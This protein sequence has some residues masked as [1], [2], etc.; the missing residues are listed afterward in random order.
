MA[1]EHNFL[2]GKGEKLTIPVEVPS[3]G[4]EKAPPYKFEVAKQRVAKK[5]ESANKI[6]SNIP[7]EACPND[8]V[9]GVITIHPRYISKSDFPENFLNQSG[10]RAIGTRPKKIKP[11]AW[12]IKKHPQEAS[13]EQI[14]VAGKKSTFNKWL[15]NI[16]SWDENSQG[17]STLSQ[18]EDFSPFIAEDKIRGIPDTKKK[19]FLEV[20]IHNLG[21]KQAI[22]E[23]SN[24]AKTLGGE[25]LRNRIRTIG[26]LTFVPT[27]IDQSRVTELATFSFVRVARGMPTVRPFPTTALRSSSGFNVTLPDQGP[28][29][30]NVR[31]VIFDGGLP[32]SVDLN[33]WCNYHE[34]VGIGNPLPGGVVHGL[35]VTSA[36]LF[37]SLVDG[38]ALRQPFCPVDHVRVIGDTDNYDLQ[39]IDI[40][41]R[42][43][44]YLDQHQ[45]EYQFVNLSLGPDFS[46]EDDEVNQWTSSLDARFCFENIMA[47]VAAGNSGERDKKLKLNRIQPP[48]D[49]VNVLS[50][51]ATD[52]LGAKWKKAS[53]SSIGPGRSPGFVKPDGV[54]FGGSHSEP[55][56]VLDA[57]SVPRSYPIQGTSFAAPFV[58]G[59]A[60][61]TKALAGNDLTP[62]ATRA[63]VIHRAEAGKHKKEEVGWG[64]LP[65]T[66]QQIMTCDDDEAL[67]VYQ[68]TL[69]IGQHLRANLPL[70][71][72]S[73]QGM[74]TLRA[75]LLIAPEVDMEHPG[76][77]TK[78][79]LEVAFR[80]NSS[81]FNK[82][83]D[84]TT[85][86]HPKTVPFFSGSKM[87]KEEEFR[88]REGGF[89]WEPCF[90]HE[91]NFRGSSMLESCFDIWYHH[92]DGATSA[93]NPQALPYALIISLKAPKEKNFY[94][95]VVRTY[96]QILIPMKPQI[97]IPIQSSH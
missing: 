53:Y 59:A 79:G 83:K 73:I 55:F 60:A 47:T 52:T 24:Y 84:G 51:G 7:K 68:G 44:N 80:P 42:I 28:V 41:D 50:V 13:T 20:A 64:L 93:E 17:A 71:S 95:R 74:V 90:R 45:G 40:L 66:P 5:L 33:L 8:E 30:N 14:F 22:E 43:T 3:G 97:Q 67:V 89:K 69:L 72:G 18:I 87:F 85:P 25:V 35:A 46:I 78:G 57:S 92:R 32:D 27:Y 12:G 1:R 70:P 37:G 29:N 62:L 6:F 21:G 26:G 86:A 4:G 56:M 94:N 31:A 39:Y 49:A 10:L 96:S 34:P 91:A 65:T 54:A 88:L 9:V 82:N 38:Q 16:K 61:G 76:A 23:Y 11:E 2:L 63:L 36:F 81:K 15:E 58:L 48:S 75:T 77:Y 19:I